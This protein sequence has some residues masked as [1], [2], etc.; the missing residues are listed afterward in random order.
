MH[1]RH[2]VWERCLVHS[3]AY[4]EEPMTPIIQL[5]RAAIDFVVGVVV[6]VV[7]GDIPEVGS[8]ADVVAC[9]CYAYSK[10]EGKQ[11]GS[12]R[13]EKQRSPSS[14]VASREVRSS[15]CSGSSERTYKHCQ[16]CKAPAT[17]NARAKPIGADLLGS[18]M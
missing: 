15:S 17:A 10:A 18:Y 16:Q 13:L 5:H 6:R 1:D 11:K 14:I 12:E 8:D 7:I 4:V 2:F 3:H 9:A